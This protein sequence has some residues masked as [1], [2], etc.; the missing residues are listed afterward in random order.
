M[1]L[2][3]SSL[4]T[5]L[6]IGTYT[7]KEGHVDG[8]AEGILRTTINGSSKT[9]STI[10]SGPNPSFIA[11]SGDGNTLY[12][13]NE[14]GGRQGEPIGRVQALRH[15]DNKWQIISDQSA[16]G[17]APCYIS[18]THDGKYVLVANY[19]S[20]TIA[21]YGIT[22]DGGLTEALHV[23]QFTGSGPD[24]RQE[25]PHAH[26]I[27]QGPD[28][29][30]Y[31][32]DLGTDSIRI[33]SLDNGKFIHHSTS[34]VSTGA[35]PRHLAHH[36][37]LPFFYAVNELNATVEVFNRNTSEYSVQTISTLI[38]PARTDGGCADIKISPDGNFLYVSNRGSYNDIVAYKIDKKSGQ[39]EVIDRYPTQGTAPRSFIITRDGSH[40]IAANQDSNDLM[41]WQ[42]DPVNGSLKTPQLVTGIPTPVCLIEI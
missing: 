26:Y 29:L 25:A 9:T 13:V 23:V 20:G 41:V 14:I 21:S 34:V 16:H 27:E 40:L 38:D 24:A 7:R 11:R 6:F 39:L 10:P 32:A 33:Y 1:S 22:A 17:I 8:K 19:V 15:Q 5:G 31:T 35:G 4:T 18:V 36:P 28:G 37:T 12:T 2:Q 3:D 30:I 42:R